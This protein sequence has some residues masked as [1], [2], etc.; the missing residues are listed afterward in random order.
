MS[1]TEDRGFFFW[2]II[3]AVVI[4]ALAVLEHLFGK[5]SLGKLLDRHKFVSLLMFIYVPAHL[6]IIRNINSETR[7]GYPGRY[8]TDRL[9]I[10]RMRNGTNYALLLGVLVSLIVVGPLNIFSITPAYFLIISLFTALFWSIESFRIDDREF[11]DTK[12]H[13][14]FIFLG[15]NNLRKFR[16]TGATY[17]IGLIVSA[18]T[19]YGL[20][21][22]PNLYWNLRM[23]P[24]IM[25]L[26][27]L[28]TGL[29]SWIPM[30]WPAN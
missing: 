12:V 30:L 10:K 15:V 11:L 19:F 6:K 21:H 26:V 23:N 17:V 8:W 29:F 5:G 16:K 28:V 4:L 22:V 27:E 13:S 1:F 20:M 18:S 25:T 3:F 24:T 9:I 7:P 14:Y 2:L